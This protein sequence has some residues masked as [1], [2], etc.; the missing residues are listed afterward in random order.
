MVIGEIKKGAAG[1]GDTL[2][3]KLGVLVSGR[4]SNLQAIIDAIDAKKINAEI[5][6]VISNVPDVQALEQGEETRH[7]D[8][9]GGRE[10]VPG[11]VRI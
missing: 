4:G 2:M 1:S 10:R 5:A 7:K 9:S 6:V 8:G 3:L 11:Q